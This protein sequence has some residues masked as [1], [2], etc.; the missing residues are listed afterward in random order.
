MGLDHGVSVAPD[1]VS[2]TVVFLA[3]KRRDVASFLLCPRLK[4]TAY[5]GPGMTTMLRSYPGDRFNGE[6]KIVHR[7]FTGYRNENPLCAVN[8]MNKAKRIG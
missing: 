6:S 8:V 7:V 5:F 4:P 2:E 3:A 1:C